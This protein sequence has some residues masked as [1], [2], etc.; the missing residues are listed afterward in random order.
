MLACW[1]T[2]RARLMVLRHCAASRCASSAT[3]DELCR[4]SPATVDANWEVGDGGEGG[5]HRGHTYCCC[6]REIALCT[7]VIC[8]SE[9]R[10]VFP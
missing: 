3:A 2:L 8:V 5:R 1:A 7:A 10:T 6:A 4:Q 9:V